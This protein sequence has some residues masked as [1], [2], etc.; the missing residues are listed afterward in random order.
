[1]SGIG[2]PIIKETYASAGVDIGKALTLKKWIGQHARS[3]FGPEV[4]GGIGFFG[5]MYEFKGYKNPILVSHV[6]GVGTKMK[7]AIA[8]GKHNTIGTDIVNHCVNDIF[9]CGAKPLFFLDYMAMGNLL[10]EVAKDIVKGLTSACK[11]VGCALIGGET[12]EMPGIYAEGDYDLVGFIIG[13][14]EKDKIML[15]EKITAGDAVLGLPSSGLHTNGY[16]LVR[17]VFGVDPKALNKHCPELGSTL[18]EALLEPHSCYYNQLK[19]LLP[20]IKGIAHIT[21]GSFYKNIPRILPEGLSGE[22]DSK[23][24][25]VPPLFNII[26]KK[27]NI[28]R[29]EMYHVF[30][31]GIGMAVVCSPEQVKP[32]LKKLPEAKVIGKVM[33][34]EGEVRVRIR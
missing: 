12:A 19:I 7:I 30:N 6:D 17:K 9:T 16:S 22:L 21:G 29:D 24:W 23:A 33:K 14:I 34:Q 4:L 26:Q 13:V 10:P 25:S 18:G 32:L 2:G 31:M 1:M 3:T 8:L 15:G 5:G 28:D 11:D 20:K 27:G